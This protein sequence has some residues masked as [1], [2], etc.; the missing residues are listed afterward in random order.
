MNLI[1]KKS[2]KNKIIIAI[3]F[4]ALFNF[5]HPGTV[6]QAKKDGVGGVLFEPIQYLVL[7]IFDG[8]NWGIHKLIVNSSDTM[9]TA[10]Q[11]TGGFGF[12]ISK[13]AATMFFVVGCALAI[14]SPIGLVATLAAIAAAGCAAKIVYE[15]LYPDELDL[16]I[17][18]VSP[19]EIISNKIGM[20]DVNFF[21]PHTEQEVKVQEGDSVKTEMKD[22]KEQ[23]PTYV[24][25]ELIARWY[26]T[27]RIIAMVGLL[28]VLAYLGIKIITSSSAGEKARFKENLTNWLTALCM[29]FILHYGMVILLHI[30]DLMTD[31]VLPEHDFYTIDLRQEALGSEEKPYKITT[32]DEEKTIE[33]WPVNLMGYIR[34]M[35]QM[36]ISIFA[37][38]TYT[39]MFGVLVIYTLMFLFI[40]FKRVVYMAFLTMIAPLIALTYPIDKAGDGK[41]QAFDAWTKE[42]IY[43][44]I[45]QPVH[46]I[47]YTVLVGSAAELAIN[48]PIYALVAIGFLFPAE[49]IIRS[50]FG[51]KNDKTMG[52]MNTALGGAMLMKGMQAVNKSVSK[53]GSGGAKASGKVEDGDST[54]TN[55][56]IRTADDNG[57]INAADVLAGNNGNNGLNG[58]N[59]QDARIPRVDDVTARERF[60]GNPPTLRMGEGRYRP[61]IG[62]DNNKDVRNS[63]NADSNLQSEREKRAEFMSRINDE[64]DRNKYLQHER[65]RNDLQSDIDA[66]KELGQSPEDYKDYQNSL[67][68]HQKQMDEI[69]DRYQSEIVIPQEMEI[70]EQ[71]TYEIEDNTADITVT[72]GQSARNRVLKNPTTTKTKLA[73]K[74]ATKVGKDGVRKVAIGAAK[75][76]VKA[77]GAG[78]GATM[79]VAAGLASDDYSNVLTYGAA[80]AGI[81]TSMGK[82]VANMPKAG[83]NK[84]SQVKEQ[85]KKAK[86][87][88]LMETA[89]ASEIRT[90]MNEKADKEFM[91]DKKIQKQY[92]MNRPEGMTRKEAM[93]KAISY[94]QQGITDNNLI[95]EAMKIEGYGE[96]DSKQ[97]IALAK[98]ASKCKTE[99]GI[100]NLEKQLASRGVPK[101]QIMKTSN[102]IR[103]I[104]GM[105]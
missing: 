61:V 75:T 69:N 30:T 80:G 35:A 14:T 54:G 48:N 19:Y 76:G 58:R 8:I 20:L 18:S 88:I 2:F 74:A 17:Y 105:E 71:P 5:I 84:A 87:E 60:G 9:I 63:L 37:E 47:L 13:A 7:A 39:I 43:N 93:E 77:I 3:V 25:R 67:D 90:H 46:L 59:G 12:W 85:Y 38:I 15:N 29:L 103:M 34:I 89:S 91:D 41:A 57:G 98:A 86:D 42:Y 65:Y 56:P 101:E 33:E 6:V 72:S 95:L 24:L 73:L 1:M 27:F 4:I 96:V 22:I 100:R 16:P 97:R 82:T 44:L 49:K 50:F 23:V 31:I 21:N 10:S 70:P 66:M 83:L 40:Y 52:A 45:I 68:Y 55:K 62:N 53:I 99:K 26:V 102:D 92:A 79:G 36:D 81:G 104:R 51:F 78:V 11:D 94:R 28:S 32:D 64:E